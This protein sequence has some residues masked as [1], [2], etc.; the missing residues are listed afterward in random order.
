MHTW[1]RLVGYL[2]PYGLELALALISMVTLAITTGSYPLLLDLLTTLL[3][4]GAQGAGEVLT[5]ALAKLTRLA[6]TLGI[7]IE[8]E[9]FASFLEAN[10]LALFGAVVAA[11]A[12]SQATRFFM[13]G[14][15]ATQVIRDLRRDLFG[16]LLH[17]D[18]TF[19]A[20]QGTGLLVSRVM[21]DVAQV[22]RVTTYAA[23]I[24]VGDALRV[25]VLATVCVVQY[26]QLS[27]VAALVI[28][29]AVVP[30]VFF[31]KALKR[32][33]RRG[34]QAVAQIT[35]RITE[36]V[37]GIRVVQAYGRQA[38]ELERFENESNLYV[39]A[40][41]KSVLVRAVQTPVME[42]VGV[43]ALLLTLGYAMQQV[44]QGAIRP[45]E[46]VG[47]LLALVLLYEPIKAIGRLNGIIVPGLVAAERVFELVD[48]TP[49]IQGGTQTLPGRATQVEF[50]RVDF[51]YRSEGPLVLSDFSLVLPPGKTVALVGPSG[52]GK[53]TVASLLLRFFD[54]VRGEVRIDGVP[55][56]RL[57]L[58]QL[59][60]QT[61]L[62][63]QET[64]L[65]NDSVRANIAYGRPDATDTEIEAAA[66]A[67]HAHD[68][69]L[70]LPQGYA[71]VTGERGVSL[72]GGQ[73]Q[74]IAIARA[75]L[76]DAPLL[77]LDEATSALDSEAEREVQAALEALLVN[78]TS[79]V[80]AHR[81]STIRRADLI[82]VLE[83]GRIVEQGS[84][85]QLLAQNGVYARLL[86]NLEP[87]CT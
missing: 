65:F 85:E 14:S 20:A 26:P 10:V 24:L 39:R 78:R 33:A 35:Q 48:R 72:S 45:G 81:L 7:A 6:G 67:A 58:D 77:I 79:L 36:T 68:F 66:R 53:S 49:Q 23:P 47:F 16:R 70:A 21:N 27:L 52:S 55:L 15:V 54:P 31:G 73:R 2:R 17:Q 74:R 8:T 87:S 83:R 41:L 63:A 32:Y 61:A 82:V 80:I 28:P 44:G 38:H 62:V 40:T 4:H 59:R 51:Q 25:L 57:R 84:H 46:V 5:P 3:I 37:G 56:P 9:A 30:I 42:L 69:I 12:L 71:T 43:L 22:E 64:Y 34:Q 19:F 1:R 29:L 86:G 11:K 18:A 50:H 60:A 13:M 75:F 76:R